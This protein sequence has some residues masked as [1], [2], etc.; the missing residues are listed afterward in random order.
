MRMI[1]DINNI[2]AVEEVVSLDATPGWLSEGEEDNPDDFFVEVRYGYGD[3]DSFYLGSYDLDGTKETYQK[4]L[5]NF[6]NI[7]IKT[8]ESG[9]FR[10]SDFE[11]FNFD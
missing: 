8:A 6:N 7:C 2:L 1:N 4:A 11:N 3:N 10:L 5:K 9:F